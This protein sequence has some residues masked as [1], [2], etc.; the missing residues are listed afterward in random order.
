LYDFFFVSVLML[1]FFVNG[2]VNHISF[3]SEGFNLGIDKSDVSASLRKL[4]SLQGNVSFELDESKSN[5]TTQGEEHL[6]YNQYIN[7]YKV[8]AMQVKLHYKQGKLYYINGEYLRDTI[9]PSAVTLLSTNILTLA[10]NE[11][12]AQKYVWE[13][14]K[15]SDFFDDTTLTTTPQPQL[16]YSIIQSQP[17]LV[18]R[19]ELFSTEPISRKAVYIDPSTGSV[20]KTTELTCSATGTAETRYSGTRSIENEMSGSNYILQATNLSR[21]III[22][23]VNATGGVNFTDADNNW[24][25]IEHNSSSDDAALD[26][27]WMHIGEWK[28]FMT[29]LKV[30][31]TETAITVRG[32]H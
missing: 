22:K 5:I 11:I 32:A 9:L 31:S 7:G 15:F 4:F 10:K 6:T 3:D 2:Q 19:I 21:G 20:I 18:Y 30:F 27:Y 13:D 23:A 17:R 29:I 14:Q 1:P 16:V 24:T 28:K 12:K 8:E 25:A 26:A